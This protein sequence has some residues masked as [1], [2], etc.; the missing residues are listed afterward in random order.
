MNKT[1]I[2]ITVDTD[3]L[4]DAKQKIPNLSLYVTECLRNYVNREQFT[5]KEQIEEK[6]LSIKN[7]ISDLKIKESILEMEKKQLA[8]LENERKIEL[9]RREKYKRWVCPI[10]QHKNFM[11]SLRCMGRCGLPM[12]DTKDTKIIFDDGEVKA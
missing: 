10:C 12:R 5:N 8:E 1:H 6:L 7:S 2:N 11:D 3:I 9:V 4:I